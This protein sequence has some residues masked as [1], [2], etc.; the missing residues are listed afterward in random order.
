MSE[1]PQRDEIGGFALQCSRGSARILTCTTDGLDSAVV[2]KLPCFDES[3]P[4]LR[5]HLR[6]RS[7]GRR[8]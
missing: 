8:L 4:W 6:R 2:R 5:Q 7:G 1:S 3:E